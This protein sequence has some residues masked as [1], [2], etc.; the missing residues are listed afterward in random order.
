MS[1]F[2]L[3]FREKVL[4]IAIANH[5]NKSGVR[6]GLIYLPSA[7][8]S[9]INTTSEHLFE[10]YFAANPASKLICIRTEMGPGEFANVL[11]KKFRA[12]HT[13]HVGGVIAPIEILPKNVEK[14]LQA[15]HEQPEQF[16]KSA[17]KEEFAGKPFPMLT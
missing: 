8:Y 11:R 14:L 3:D 9:K 13:I 2:S 15:L 1:L 12:Q 5:D 6:E 4:H 10:E 17:E 7:V 16:L